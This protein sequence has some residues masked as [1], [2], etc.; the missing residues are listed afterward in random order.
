MRNIR[1]DLF[2]AFLYNLIGVPVAA[3]AL[4]PTFGIL[5][6]A[7][8]ASAAMALSSVS[9]I[10]DAPKARRTSI[11]AYPPAEKVDCAGR[12]VN[13]KA[14]SAHPPFSRENFGRWTPVHADL[15]EGLKG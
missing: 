5:L 1:Q 15:P 12:R 7:M 14:A 11:R 13:H 3:S 6:N 8:I 2:L 9:V 10:T 4:Y